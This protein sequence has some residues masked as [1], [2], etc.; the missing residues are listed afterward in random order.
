[1]GRIRSY[2]IKSRGRVFAI[3]RGDLH[4]HADISVDG[5]GD[6]SLLDAYRYARDAAGLDFL[7]ISDHT[8]H[9]NEPYTWWRSQKYAALN[10]L[11]NFV[12]FYGY[13]RSV[14]FPNG[15]RNVFFTKRGKPILPILGQEAQGLEGAERLFW[16][17]R[18]Q[19]GTSI[20]HTTVGGNDWRDH[21]PRVEHLVEIYQGLR[22][23]YESPGAPRPGT[24][25]PTPVESRSGHV[26]TALKKGYKLGF[27]ASSDHHSTHL[28][29]ACLLAE[30]LTLDDL[31]Q[32]IRTRRA[33]A[34]TDNIIMDLRFFGSDGEHL[35]GEEFS[36][37]TPVRLHVKIIGT[38]PILR[39]DVIR[40]NKIIYQNSPQK[41]QI[42]FEFVE[43][44]SLGVEHYYYVR[45]MQKNGMMAW[46]SPVWVHYED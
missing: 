44:D 14:A 9:V 45:V 23:S 37:A 10:Q 30:Q 36:S 13:E 8:V 21:D 34:A 16:Y 6:G 24:L 41:S 5:A 3:F 28:S 35:M 26:S 7:G 27:I 31:M 1:M 38:A 29:Y 43:S 42:T 4:R 19:G 32:A 2:R 46:S 20:P 39:V 18:R 22:D 40:D 12:A 33:Y 11:D 15:H 25:E 17:L